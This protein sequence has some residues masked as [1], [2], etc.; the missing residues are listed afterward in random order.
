MGAVVDEEPSLGPMDLL[1]LGAPQQDFA[2]DEITPAKM[3]R[4]G[5]SLGVY[6]A[7]PRGDA[8]GKQLAGA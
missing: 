2:Q 5:V 1:E 4:P 8:A 7:M 3:E 6:S